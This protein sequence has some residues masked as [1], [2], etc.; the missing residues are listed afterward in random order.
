MNSSRQQVIAAD[1]SCAASV[2]RFA[3]AKNSFL[4]N[5]T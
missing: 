4:K 1:A 3:T 5:K 2:A